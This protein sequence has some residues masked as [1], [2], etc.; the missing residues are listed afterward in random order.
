MEE[1]LYA[2]LAVSGRIEARLNDR[3]RQR[4]DAFLNGILRGAGAMIGFAL[5]GTV[6]VWILQY[7][8]ERNL[9]VI[10]DFLAE[11]VTMVRMRIQ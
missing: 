4:L 7:L 6:G 8:A 10:S 11:V 5:M 1:L 2:L 9:P 3:K